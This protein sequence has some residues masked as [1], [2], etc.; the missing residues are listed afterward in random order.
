MP[1]DPVKIRAV[2]DVKGVTQAELAR[3]TGIAPPN[4]ARILSGDRTDP[5]LSTAE[6]IASA[7]KTPLVKLT[8][9]Q[10]PI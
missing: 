6:R 7:L 8:A 9:E 5:A 3:R 4:I 1:L 10:R 2:M